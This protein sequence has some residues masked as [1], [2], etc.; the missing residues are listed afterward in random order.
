MSTATANDIVVVDTDMISFII[1]G[2]TRTA[3]YQPHLDGRLQ[4]IAAKRARN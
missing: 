1:K 3:L 2:D 4:I